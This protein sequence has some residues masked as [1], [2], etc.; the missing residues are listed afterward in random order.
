MYYSFSFQYGTLEPLGT[1]DFYPGT[2]KHYGCYQPGCYDGF[3]NVIS[4]SHSRS[5]KIYEASI[6]EAI[7][8]ADRKCKG[9]PRKFPSNCMAMNKTETE[10][11]ITMGYWW[12][13]ANPEPGMYTV[14]V[15]YSEPY[16]K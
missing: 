12:D 11:F 9:D 15:G 2:N 6:T 4:C 16:S 3:F 14:E 8:L 13:V 5:R 7:C 10:N 1:A